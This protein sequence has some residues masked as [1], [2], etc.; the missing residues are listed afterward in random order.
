V[1]KLT[2][3]LSKEVQMTSKCMKM[4]NIFNHQGN[5]NQN[6]IEVS[7]HPSQNG[8]H[9]ENKHQQMLAR[10]QGKRIL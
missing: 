1:G 3:H 7:S 9:Q 4:F 10:V 6:N 8:C 5:G 2:E